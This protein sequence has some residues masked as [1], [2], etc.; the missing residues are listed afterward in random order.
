[1]AHV[2]HLV[3]I[4]FRGRLKRYK[5]K[6]KTIKELVE[7]VNKKLNHQSFYETM[8]Y[9]EMPRQSWTKIQDGAGVKEKNAIRIGNILNIDPIEIM[10]ISMALQAKN[11]EAKNLWLKLAKEKENQRLN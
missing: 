8:T 5:E 9:L 11:K 3:T 1:M 7:K 10:A 4:K 2:N 6:M